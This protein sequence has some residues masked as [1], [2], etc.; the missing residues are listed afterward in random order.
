MICIQRNAPN[1]LFV[2]Y[3]YLYLNLIDLSHEVNSGF[4]K[5]KM[6]FLLKFYCFQQPD[7]GKHKCHYKY[8]T[9]ILRELIQIFS[10]VIA[11]S[12]KAFT[13]QVS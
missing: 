6:H 11:I 7:L 1:R 13:H 12:E 9:K 10:L 2:I 8:L 5:V 3:Y 4:K